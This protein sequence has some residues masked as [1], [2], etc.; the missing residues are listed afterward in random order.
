MLEIIQNIEFVFILIISI[1]IGWNLFVSSTYLKKN[2]EIFLYIT[3][4]LSNKIA[5][6]IFG[7]SEILY[8]F[9]HSFAPIAFVISGIFKNNSQIKWIVV[10]WLFVSLT[11]WCFNNFF[12][13]VLVY[14]MA[15][16]TLMSQSINM[17][18]GRST[19]LQYSYL[20][21]VIAIDLFFAL[22]AI[23]LK[24]KGFNWENSILIGYLKYL[25]I[26]FS[27]FTLVIIYVNSRRHTA[28]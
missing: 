8:Y 12:A 5:Y 13:F 3:V 24:V 21:I 25:I 17:A 2:I 18:N 9:F 27:L 6:L 26:P 4:L 7:K 28:N 14:C 23:I 19:K 20:P 16:G 1:Q 11:L 22:T 15:I 10:C